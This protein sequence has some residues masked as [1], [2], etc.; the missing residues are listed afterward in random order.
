[1]W[2]RWP[3]ARRAEAVP[4]PEHAHAPIGWC[5]ALCIPSLWMLFEQ[6]FKELATTAQVLSLL[7]QQD[8]NASADIAANGWYGGEM[9]YK[10]GNQ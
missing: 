10:S 2:K 9:R 3:D 5:V 6:Y 7:S 8:R 4:L 1:M